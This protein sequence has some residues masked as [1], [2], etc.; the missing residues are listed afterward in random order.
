MGY[1]SF[2]WMPDK[3][4]ICRLPLDL[5]SNRACT[6]NSE[7]VVRS[8]GYLRRFHPLDRHARLVSNQERFDVAGTLAQDTMQ[9]PGLDRPPS[10]LPVR[11]GSAST[12]LYLH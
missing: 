1:K 5:Y 6:F 10:T 12:L 3:N 7:E 9:S 4:G 8:F 11:P 2:L